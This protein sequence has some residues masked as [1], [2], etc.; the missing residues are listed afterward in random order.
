MRGIKGD[1]KSFDYSS[2][3]C[4]SLIAALGLRVEGWGLGLE[5]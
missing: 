3:S 2:Y 1:T 5:V 4:V